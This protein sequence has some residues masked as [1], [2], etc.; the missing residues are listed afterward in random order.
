MLQKRSHDLRVGV[1]FNTEVD[2]STDYTLSKAVFLALRDL[3]TAQAKNFITKLVKEENV[4]DLKEAKK[5]LRD[6]EV[7]VSVFLY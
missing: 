5:T 7:S 1:I 6:F 3:D 2:D 4:K